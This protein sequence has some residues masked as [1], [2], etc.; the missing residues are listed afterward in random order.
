MYWSKLT[1]E[2][3]CFRLFWL[4]T[5]NFNDQNNSAK[6]DYLLRENY[7]LHRYSRKHN[8]LILRT[9]T[10]MKRET[11]LY[12]IFPFIA[13]TT[14]EDILLKHL[15]QTKKSNHNMA[16]N[17]YERNQIA[18][19]YFW[20]LLNKYYRLISSDTIFIFRNHFSVSYNVRVI[21]KQILVHLQ[22]DSDNNFH[23]SLC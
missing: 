14:I 18:T 22:G 15:T 13:I 8:N 2:L 12:P 21:F 9:F 3:T 11:C 23:I 4:L 10:W 5:C 6:K 16:N 20:S 7:I 1:V 19:N 17:V